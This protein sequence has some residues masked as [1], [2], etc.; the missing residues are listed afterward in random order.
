MAAFDGL[1]AKAAVCQQM[2]E[3]VA[4]FSKRV[5]S[6]T[7]AVVNFD[8]SAVIELPQLAKEMCRCIKMS[9]LIKQFA[10]EAGRLIHAIIEL[11]QQTADKMGVLFA[12][13]DHAKDCLCACAREA[14]EAKR[15][16]ADAYGDG[17]A[18][19]EYTLS[20]KGQLEGFTRLDPSSLRA[21]Q[22]LMRGEEIRAMLQLAEQMDELVVQCIEKVANMIRIVTEGFRG[23]PEI[24]TDGISDLTAADTSDIA[25]PAN[26]ERDIAELNAATEAINASNLLSAVSA[27]VKG[28]SGTAAKANVCNEMLC[29]TQD[30]ADNTSQTVEVFM[31]SWNLDVMGNKVQ[32]IFRCVKLGTV[33][34]QFSEQTKALVL[35]IVALLQA[36]IQKFSQMES[37]QL[38]DVAEVFKVQASEAV[39]GKANELLQGF[40]SRFPF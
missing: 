35:S 8:A 40:G 23:L 19:V 22:Q 38:D 4:S 36:T 26:T 14:R 2:F 27:G 30:F 1:T 10:T 16:C 37:V 31:G 20:V 32:E 5:A 39:M 25:A 9:S 6:I 34:Q 15:L 7:N 3:T 21:A 12:A 18:L 17:K 33:M 24:I 29:A 28:F 13:L 11:F